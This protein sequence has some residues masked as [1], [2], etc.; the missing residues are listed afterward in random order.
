MHRQRAAPV[1]VLNANT[2]R[3][4]GREAQLGNI[5]A[6]K[7]VSDVVR[8]CLGPKSMLKMILSQSGGI[9]VTN[10]GNAILREVNV[11]HPAAKSM[12]DLSRAQDEEVGDGTTSVIVLAGEILSMAEPWI[13]K[14]LH[15]RVIISGYLRALED[16]LEHIKL[17]SKPLD[18]KN[19]SELR[20]IIKS[21]IGTKLIN[22]WS[23]LM[24]E[25]ALK[26]V[27]VVA[28]EE[29]GR[30]E[31]ELKRY[32]RIEKV[33]G[34]DVVDSE[35]VYGVVMNKDVTHASMR[36]RIVNPRVILLDCNLEYKKS[37]NSLTHKVTNAPDW[38]KIMK[39][40]EDQVKQ[41]VL[42]IC[43][44]K[45]DVVITEKGV[46][47]EA[48]HW[49]V[50]HGVTALRRVKKTTND[51]IARATGATIVNRPEELKESDVGTRC[52]LFEVK[53]IGDE[54]YTFLSECKDAKACTIL[55]RGASKDFLNEVERNLDDA[56]AVARNI[57]L[58]P[59]ICPGGGATEM[60]V[61]T[62]LTEKA[63][64]IAGVE[65]YPYQS[66]AIALEVIPRTLI[67]NCGADIVKTIT[68][69][70]AKHATGIQTKY[71]NNTWGI[72]GELGELVDMTKLGV[73][74]PYVVKVQSIKTAIEAATMLLRI[75]DIVSGMS[76]KDHGAPAM[77][78]EGMMGGAPEDM[79][80]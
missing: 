31:V 76:K 26:A 70:R 13:E 64:S 78:G 27:R 67:Q 56:L 61:A 50:K 72:D 36:R 48:Q 20:Q 63:K 29:N 41:T 44:L 74:E 40:E 17:I 58:D 49:F 71:S 11:S 14:K 77:G 57:I 73:W 53:K 35:L 21:C 2:K 38:E 3:E 25:L 46:S 69:L 30:R 68:K 80:A 79:E 10:D 34:G 5:K 15:P 18:T 60:S 42:A 45:P 16:A 12:I 55:L 6:A 22:S 9:V 23:D 8:T 19:D 39:Q 75:D 37:A 1:L 54:Y 43:K 59:R 7:A 33:P 62:K 65:Q 28:T 4:T 32:C 47:D 24:C 51:R 52:G 66:V